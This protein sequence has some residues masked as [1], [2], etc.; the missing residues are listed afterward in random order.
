MYISILYNYVGWLSLTSHRQRGHLETVPHLMS[1]VKDVKLGQCTVPI[2]N[3]TPGRRVAVDY[4][5]AA[6]R[7]L[8]ILY[9]IVTILSSLCV[10]NLI[11]LCYAHHEFVF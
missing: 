10:C 7:K 6:P 9:I 2:G 4:A 1:L 8:H 5:T 3:R 11:Y